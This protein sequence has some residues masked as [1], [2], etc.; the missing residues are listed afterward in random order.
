LIATVDDSG[1][2]HPVD[3]VVNG[4]SLGPKGASR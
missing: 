1:A 4:K 3:L 2:V